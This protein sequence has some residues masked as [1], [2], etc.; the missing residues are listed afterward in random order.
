MKSY[1]KIII[2]T[3]LIVYFILQFNNI[4]S[5][6]LL[7]YEYFLLLVFSYYIILD[8]LD[9]YKKYKN[10]DENIFFEKLFIYIPIVLLFT[11][12][13]VYSTIKSI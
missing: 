7:Y 6:Y 3:L 5:N 1:Q 4:Q 11:L 2:I 12:F 10:R 9:N 8:L 13:L